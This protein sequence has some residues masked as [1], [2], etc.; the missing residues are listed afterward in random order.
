[1]DH[2]VTDC[3]YSLNLSEMSPEQLHRF[4]SLVKANFSR[5]QICRYT[6]CFLPSCLEYE[7][8]YLFSLFLSISQIFGF[9]EPN[10]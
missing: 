3:K 10:S 9:S 6:T 8:Q 4:F 1:M 5:T 7:V 2:N